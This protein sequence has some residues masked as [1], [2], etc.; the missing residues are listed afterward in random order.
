MKI[1]FKGSDS[2][3]SNDSI[4]EFVNVLFD[5]K[6]IRNVVAKLTL[7]NKMYL[8]MFRFFRKSGINIILGSKN[9]L[10]AD[11]Y[12]N[13][14]HLFVIMMGLDEYKYRPFG[15][16]NK[17]YK[18]IYLFDAWP[19]DYLKIQDFCAR[20]KINYL[21]VT[22][23]Q[24]AS[25]LQNKLDKTKVRWIPEG[26]DVSQ[27][28][29]ESY[30]SKTIDVLALG[31][32]YDVYHQLIDVGLAEKGYIYRYE[33][34]KGELVFPTREEFIQGLANSKIS[35]CVPSNIT[36]PERSG[37]VETMTIRYLQSMAS[38]CL[39]VGHAPAEMIELFGYNP[40]IE[41]DMT[42]AVSQLDNILNNY[43]HYIP[44]IEKNYQ[45]VL[46]NHTWLHRWNQIVNIWSNSSL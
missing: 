7:M 34:Q 36:H 39:I 21:Y 2:H 5:L 11:P 42:N 43:D 18:S 41:I 45:A 8:I 40:V 28:K 29:Y 32:K 1:V 23:S 46:E 17:N 31:R 14:K 22:A 24:S 26:V 27:Y 38:K 3:V 30:T 35:I 33:K 16:L 9:Q 12:K 10:K 20:Y 19:K 44:L 15:I 37:D 4:S 13:N 25:R 6:G